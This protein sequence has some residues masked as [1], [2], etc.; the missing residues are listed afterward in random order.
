ML[1]LSAKDRGLKLDGPD[2]RR[3][4]AIR[5]PPGVLAAAVLAAEDES[6]MLVGSAALWLRGEPMSVGDA[7]AVIEP[8]EHS[9]R[10]AHAALVDMAI[11]P[12]AGSC[13]TRSARPLL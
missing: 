1:P 11:R 8:G 12:R 7:D 5:Y 3:W 4:Q 2:S 9:L 6:L 13:H 10:R